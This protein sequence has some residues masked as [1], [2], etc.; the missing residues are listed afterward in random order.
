MRHRKQIYMMTNSAMGTPYRKK[1]FR[2]VQFWVRLANI[3]QYSA[4]AWWFTSF[5]Y[6]YIYISFTCDSFIMFSHS[7]E[8]PYLTKSCKLERP[9]VYVVCPCV[10]MINI[11]CDMILKIIFIWINNSFD[12]ALCVFV[13]IAEKSTSAAVWLKISAMSYS[14]FLRGLSDVHEY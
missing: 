12:D 2:L 5:T 8:T 7:P 3:A 13:R 11:F 10:S 1:V 9:P 6:I 14:L 4:F